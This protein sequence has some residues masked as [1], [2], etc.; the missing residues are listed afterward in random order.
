MKQHKW[1]KEIKAWADGLTIQYK[2][3]NFP[4]WID[5][6]DPDWDTKSYIEFRIKPQPK[7]PKQAWDEEL[8]RSYKETIIERLRNDDKF[9]DEVFSAYDNAKDNEIKPQPIP[10]YKGDLTPTHVKEPKYLHV[11]LDDDYEFS[12]IKLNTK[13]TYIG[14]IK[15]EAEN[16]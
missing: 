14:K 12:P 15:L 1:H 7:T 5:T 11:Y 8:T 9:Y 10:S 16:E 2:D 6:L 13:W 3:E 4:D